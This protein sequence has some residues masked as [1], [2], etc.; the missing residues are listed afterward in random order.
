[1]NKKEYASLVAQNIRT[2][3]CTIPDKVKTYQDF[4]NSITKLRKTLNS[5]LDS[6]NT[7]S[8]MLKTNSTDSV[9]LLKIIK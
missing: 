9:F 4:S 2:M 7:R 8:T 3:H 6:R 5:T 1:M